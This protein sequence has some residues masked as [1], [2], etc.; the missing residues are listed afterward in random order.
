M[1]KSEIIVPYFANKKLAREL[2]VESDFVGTFS[3][4]ESKFVQDCAGIVGRFLEKK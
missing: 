2:D 1:V 4:G 3:A